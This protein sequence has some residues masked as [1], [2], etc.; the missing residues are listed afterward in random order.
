MA[1]FHTHVSDVLYTAEQV[2]EHLTCGT[3]SRYRLHVK[4]RCKWGPW[5]R[6]NVIL[7]DGCQAWLVTKLRFPTLCRSLRWTFPPHFFFWLLSTLLCSSPRIPYSRASKQ[8]RRLHRRPSDHKHAFLTFIPLL[9]TPV[10][11]SHFPSTQLMATWPMMDVVEGA[12]LG[13]HVAQVNLL[14]LYQHL[15]EAKLGKDKVRAHSSQRGSKLPLTSN[16]AHIEDPNNTFFFFWIIEK[17]VVYIGSALNCGCCL[18]KMIG[19]Q[20]RIKGCSCPHST[21]LISN[22]M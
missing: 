16:D 9:P 2:L 13:G 5:I 1:C 22:C 11:P 20:L 15:E 3:S 6:S 10:L 18:K 12:T 21:T 7:P 14:V 4:G 19:Y 17:G 8:G